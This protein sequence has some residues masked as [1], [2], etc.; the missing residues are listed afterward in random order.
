M[1]KRNYKKKGMKI[2][3]SVRTLTFPIPDLSKSNIQYVDISQ[4]ASLVNRRFYRQGLNWAVAGFS[5]HTSNVDA[6]VGTGSVSIAKIPST[7]IA[8]NGWEKAFRAWN[9]QQMDAVSDAGALSAVAKFRDFKIHADE[10][11]VLEGFST[12]MKPG[13]LMATDN[14]EF[15]S[16]GEWEPSEIVLPN[17]DL[18]PSSGARTEPRQNYLHMTGA[19]EYVTGS[20]V[21]SRGIMEGYAD[22][23]AYPQ[24]PDP[25]SPAIDSGNNWLRAMFDVGND[26]EEITE[27]AT[28]T[29]DDLPY[30]QVDYPGG[31]TQAPGLQYHD[32]LNITTTTVSGKTTCRGTT[33]PCGLLRFNIDSSLGAV[34]PIPGAEPA[35]IAWIQLHLV[36]GNHRG[37]LCEPMTEM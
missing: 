32:N 13:V 20:G 19:N 29:N 4:A 22:S 34:A 11:H 31:Q 16:E 30:P 9:R 25:V 15:Y 14:W 3:P 33:V 36:P 12:N 8:S 35:P 10:T 17:A 26:N 2:Q 23:R 37:Y 18:D 7:W 28:D 6:S 1:A 21:A 27:N 5:L 24:S